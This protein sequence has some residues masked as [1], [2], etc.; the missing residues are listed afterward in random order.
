M[1]ESAFL[2]LPEYLLL[3]IVTLWCDHEA[4]CNLDSAVCNKSER[5]GFLIVFQM[6]QSSL[7]TAPPK[8]FSATNPYRMKTWPAPYFQWLFLRNI[9]LSELT[10]SNSEL[11]TLL[12]YNIK[13]HFP[14]IRTLIIHCTPLYARNFMDS[15]LV[16]ILNSC[17]SL[18]TL[19]FPYVHYD[20]KYL[21]TRRDDIPNFGDAKS[22]ISK[23][24]LTEGINSSNGRNG[25]MVIV[26]TKYS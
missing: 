13:V 10:I 15:I 19:I 20:V 3:E 4:L 16:H 14:R 2:S 25:L 7:Y 18:S 5:E 9:Y 8:V 21:P 22:F 17:S 24:L 26:G 12:Q 6:M 11:F 1:S 23:A